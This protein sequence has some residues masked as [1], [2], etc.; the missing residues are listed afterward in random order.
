MDILYFFS[1]PAVPE[2][3]ALIAARRYDAVY[4]DSTPERIGLAACLRA[5]KK[6]DVLH[7]VR[8]THLGDGMAD[9]VEILAS[10][11]RKG[12]DVHLGRTGATLHAKTSPYLSLSATV[13]AAYSAFVNAMRRHRAV[14]G[15]K[16]ARAAGKPWGKP[17]LPLPEN[18]AE[19]VRGWREGKFASRDAALR[20]GMS[21][22]S[23][24]RRARLEMP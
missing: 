24:L 10:L 6:G 14:Q 20:C 22:S 1:N 23:F 8:E 11:A 7:I 13:V 18:F 15:M 3:N 12:V 2:S 5:L 16:K 4:S 21:Q 19:M 9:V 17:C